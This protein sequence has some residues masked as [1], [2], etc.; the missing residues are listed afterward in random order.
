M[1]LKRIFDANADF[2]PKIKQIVRT[3]RN[4]EHYV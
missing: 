3:I 2:M 4:G 1:K